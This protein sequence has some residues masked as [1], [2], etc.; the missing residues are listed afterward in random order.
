[1]ELKPNSKLLN[2]VLISVIV[3]ITVA[4]IIH[5][6]FHIYYG[7]LRAITPKTN[8]SENDLIISE[9]HPVFAL[10]VA[11]FVN[12][13]EREGNIV[14]LNSGYRS[15]EYQQQ[16]INQGENAAQPFYSYHNYGLAV[17]MNVNNLK[18]S[19]NKQQWQPIASLAKSLGFRWGG[20]FSSN[21]DPIHFDLGSEHEISNL[22]NAYDNGKLVNNKYVK[23]F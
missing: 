11:R 18:E 21:Y 23:L 16:L 5:F 8:S 19:T 15:P 12:R 2:R 20:D 3:S 9:L 1:M 6:R 22:K 7:F 10:K 14:K 13:L 4:L 17:D